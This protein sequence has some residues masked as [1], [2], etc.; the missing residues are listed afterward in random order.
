M[1]A[2]CQSARNE[3]FRDFDSLNSQ[4]LGNCHQA[5]LQAVQIL[6]YS[7]DQKLGNLFP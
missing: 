5:P 6:G 1:Q 2:R 4:G 3:S 7:R